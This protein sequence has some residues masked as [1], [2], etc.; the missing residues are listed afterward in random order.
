MIV[1]AISHEVETTMNTTAGQ[2]AVEGELAR[3]AIQSQISMGLWIQATSQPSKGIFFPF[4]IDRD[5]AN[6]DLSPQISLEKL[7]NVKDVAGLFLHRLAHY[8]L[9]AFPVKLPAIHR[10]GRSRFRV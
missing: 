4:W 8:A 10:R 2:T 7:F 1:Q 3:F 6:A 9:R 5:P